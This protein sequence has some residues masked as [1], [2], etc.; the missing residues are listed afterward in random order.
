MSIELIDFRNAPATDLQMVRLWRNDQQVAKYFIIDEI[1]QEMHGNWLE[2]K[3]KRGVDQAFLITDEDLPTGCVYLRNIEH[4]KKTAELGIFLKPSSP[5]GKKIGSKA[6]YKILNYA[7]DE[8]GLGKV[9]LQVL[10][11]NQKA[12]VLYEKFFFDLEESKKKSVRKGD[13]YLDLDV[14]SITKDKWN[15]NKCELSIS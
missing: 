3:I 9:Y 12:K 1:S 14:M 8:I 6:L 11:D 7:F 10:G 13:L 15:N 4:V 5:T 2:T